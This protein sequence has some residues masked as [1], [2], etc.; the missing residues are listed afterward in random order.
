M[1]GRIIFS[2]ILVIM[3]AYLYHLNPHQVTITLPDNRNISIPV[4]TL[5]LISF[6]AGVVF[7]IL[8]NIYRDSVNFFLK[9]KERRK[10]RL[11]EMARELFLKGSEAFRKGDLIKAR[12][13]LTKSMGLD[14][15]HLDTYLLLADTLRKENRIDEALAVLNKI[16]PAD[17]EDIRYLFKLEELYRD[18]GEWDKA[19]VAV[20]RIL[21]KDESNLEAWKRLRDIEL[22]G[23]NIRDAFIAQRKVT[24][25]SKGIATWEEELKTYTG[26]KY[27]YAKSLFE[28]GK[29]D[30][31]KRRLKEIIRVN[32]TFIPAIL[33]LGEV[34]AKIGKEDGAIKIWMDGYNETRNPVFIQYIEEMFIKEEAPFE[35]LRIYQKRLSEDPSDVKMRILYAKLCLRLEMIDEAISEIMKLEQ[36]GVEFKPLN[37]MLG[38]A[39]RKRGRYKEASEEF[40]KAL[41]IDQSLKLTFTCTVCGHEY[42]GWVPRC[43]NCRS[44]NSIDLILIQKKSTFIPREFMLM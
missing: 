38:E 13:V 7:V 28:E 6:A 11:L 32:K 36:S 18:M 2:L 14:P 43:N 41:S 10:K 23:K 39:Y 8:V 3:F 17:R 19:R 21:K 30:K 16:N 35:I 40:R 20:Q 44:W 25:L 9:F 1:Y 31:A 12:T 33:L 24:K 34:Y 27:E 5:V 15:A 29:Y 26:L 37:L 22:A 4:T 42:P